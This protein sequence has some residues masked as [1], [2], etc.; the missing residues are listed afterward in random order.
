MT[1]TKTTT[2]TQLVTITATAEAPIP[3]STE[4]PEPVGPATTISRDGTFVVNTDVA[5]GTYKT[6]GPAGGSSFCSWARLNQ[7]A[8]ITD[9]D[10]IIK[11]GIESGPGFVTIEPSDV[12][13]AS[14]S[15]QPWRKIG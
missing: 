6:A 15:C 11:N 3:T 9:T 7:L 1:A 4:P 10:A 13:F 8:G 5:P 2:I 12:A 14:Q